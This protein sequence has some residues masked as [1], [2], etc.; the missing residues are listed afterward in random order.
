MNMSKNLVIVESPAKAKT[1]EKFLG[2]D[3]HVLSS[4]GHV[5][6]IEPVGK[7]SLGIDFEHGYEPHYAVEPQKE[8]LIEQLRKEAQK[9]DTVWLASDEDREGEAIAWHLKEVLG[10]DKKDTKRIVFHEIT[11]NAILEAID[12]PRD[13][14]Y[15][16]V[17]AQQARRVLDRIVGFELSPIL[18]KKVTTG[19][20]AGRVQSV[21]VRL[22]VEK[23]REIEAFRASSAY[24]IFADFI[25]VNP[26]DASVLKCELNHRFSHKKD[27]IEFLESLSS[28]MFI[29]R[30]VQ[31]KPVTHIPAPPFTTSTLQQEAARKLKFSV[32]KTMRLA[33]SLYESGKITYMRTDS[34]NL[35]TLA[36]AT[37]KEVI[38]E[39]FGSQYVHTRQFRTKSKGAQEAHEAIRPTY[40]STLSAG[41][42]KDE[43]R[44]YELIWKRTIASQMAEAQS[45]KT[46]IE[47]SV[48][49]S[50]Y[51]FVA[52]GEVITFD[53]FTRV[54]VQSTDEEAEERRTL[55]AM[56]PRERLKLTGAEAVQTYAKP[57]FRFN[58]AT[59]VKRM[60]ELGIGR[61][62]TYATIIDTIQKVKYVE[63]GSVAGTKRDV[64]ILT[65]KNG[66]VL[67]KQKTELY[68]AE[69]QRLLP[70]DLGRITNDFLV[71]H[72]PEILSY[73]FTAHEEEQF[74]RIAVGRAQWQQTVDSFYKT[75]KPLLS[76][77][78]SGKVEARLLGNDPA[79][80]LPIYAKISKIGPCVQ[81]GEVKDG[82]PRFASL[83]KGQSIF[84]ITL[85]EAL[86]LFKTS[87]PLTLGEYEG[88]EVIIGEGKF[89]PYVHHN[90][91]FVSI[92]K[93][94]DPLT[95]TLDE[96]IELIKQRQQTETPIHQWGDIQVLNGRY[97]AYI[98]TPEGN[99]QLSKSTDLES[100]T[101]ADVRAII[102][103]NEAIQPG[104][105]PF[106]RKSAK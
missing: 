15:N 98:H 78:S 51:A 13:I 31:R 43:Q 86:E 56:S 20:S 96:A 64:T 76:S 77:I 40:M 73:D 5:R 38:M 88:K 27:A 16:L 10:L 75:F 71:K 35:S 106:R 63:R 4:Q 52:T 3:Y 62:S 92:P 105:R 97:G 49:G 94:K 72:F 8:H 2:K 55:P 74:D 9:A 33:Q 59:L 65:L 90:K 17:N 21:A 83:K 28:A 12:N 85:N 53:G 22:I 45:E 67:E 25:G 99:F 26:G 29:V 68:G 79:T 41:E 87:L 93:G 89:G 24:R 44:L 18:W 39:Q 46:T 66:M 101:E 48:H 32:S 84:S 7:N 91:S 37:S 19:L 103:K 61:P 42:T 34:V 36:L 11:K 82:K 95:I 102:E 80:G 30:D 50:K 58:E 54:Y 6:D 14:D 70:T 47:V 57:P 60:E 100:L 1:I 104:K 69:S 81:L 23:E